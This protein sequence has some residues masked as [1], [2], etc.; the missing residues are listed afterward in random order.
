MLSLVGTAFIV[1]LMTD[2]N[3]EKVHILYSLAKSKLISSSQDN[4]KEVF[5]KVLEYQDKFNVR[6]PIYQDY[7]IDR[8]LSYMTS[9]EKY[10]Q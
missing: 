6:K 1:F 3:R 10:Q 9:R 7:F 5:K 4:T 2:K 8:V